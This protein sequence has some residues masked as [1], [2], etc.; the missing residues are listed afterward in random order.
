MTDVLAVAALEERDP[1]P[2]LVLLEADDAAPHGISLVAPAGAS[3]TVSTERASYEQ[4]PFGLSLLLQELLPRVEQVEL[5]TR[6]TNS[7]GR[8]DRRPGGRRGARGPSGPRPCAG[9]RRDRPCPTGVSMASPAV[10]LRSVLAF[11][12]GRPGQRPRR[13]ARHRPGPGTAA[14]AVAASP[15]GGRRR[16]RPR[17]SS[18]ATLSTSVSITSRTKVAS[19]GSTAYSRMTWKP[20][21]ATFSVRIERFSTSTL[22]RWRHGGGDQERQQAVLRRGS[23]RTRRRW[24]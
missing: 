7:W 17:G 16:A 14:G 15:P 19:S 4:H 24:R 23:A 5:V 6:P 13:A 11:E 12:D 1:V 22:T 10:R 3:S 20:R 2:H 18:G 8:R 21:R 9:S